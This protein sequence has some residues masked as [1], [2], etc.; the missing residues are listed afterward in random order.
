MVAKG[1]RGSPS[2]T[3]KWKPGDPRWT[4][5]VFMGAD[6]LSDEADLSNEAR[7][8]I[9]EMRR[10][11]TCPWLNIFVQ[12]HGKG[13][14]QR[15]HIGK[16]KP[17]DVHEAEADATNGQALTSFMDWA[18]KT[19]EHR[20]RDHSIL[21][22]WGHAYRFGIGHR[23]TNNGRSDALDFAELASVL[24]GFQEKHLEQHRKE[25]RAGE[26]PMLDI[27]GFDAC[28]LATIEMTFQLH[29][30]ANYLLASQIAI[31]LPGWPYDSILD[32]LYSPAGL[33]MKPPEF[34]SYVV[35][36][37]CSAYEAENRT[38]S[39]TL[40]DLKRAPELSD[41]AE[42]LARKLAIAGSLDLDE[43]ALIH[44]LFVRARTAENKPFVDVAS[45]CHSLMQHSGSSEVREA[46]EKLGDL[47]ISPAFNPLAPAP[48]KGA[49][50]GR[51]FVVEHGRN[52][53]GT[54]ALH[55][56]SLYA[57]HVAEG[58]DFASASHFYEKFVF[59]RQT[60]WNDLVR[61]LAMP[62]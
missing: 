12:L 58:H 9:E 52:A 20:R 61:T 4:V 41:L 53:A 10:V 26:M 33:L 37:Y 19:A 57:P 39:L 35:R 18:L 32:R 2:T 14:V 62:N 38:V 15:Q 25:Y 43:E 49:T 23:P 34:G 47:L 50:L 46:A 48:P 24:R 44:D 54:A 22:L 21:V 60:L 17:F 30:F 42:N 8:D 31:P 56:V 5:M 7:K 16:G 6:N 29:E 45:L 40:L 1:K 13:F 28:D 3:W 27:V 36:R 51:P 55:G 59:A 11:R